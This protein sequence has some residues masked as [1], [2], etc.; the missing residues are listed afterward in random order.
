VSPARRRPAAG[1]LP[2]RAEILEFLR[3]A[4]G[5]AKPAEI[6][7]AFGVKGAERAELRR[8]LRA[9]AGDGE[10]DRGE[11]RRLRPAGS[12]PP[13]GV[14]EVVG[15]DE[16]GEALAR[17][18]ERGN[19]DVPVRI[20]PGRHGR[21]PAT[22]DRV[23]ARLREGDDGWEGSV[24]RVLPQRAD[25]VVGVLARVGSGLHLRPATRGGGTEHVVEADGGAEP[26]DLVLAEVAP[27]GRLGLPRARVVER[28]GKPDDPAAISLLAA[29][30]ADI[31]LV[32]PAD[33][34]A[35][36]DRAAPVG[37]EG[38]TD[39]RTLPL[40]TIDGEDARDF[41][42]A[43]H[44]AADDDP[45]NPGGW[46]VTVA[47][48]D[49]AWYVR[50]G[51][52]IDREAALRGNS[53]Y[54]PDRV[55]PMLPEALSADLCSLRPDE[56]RACLAVHMRIGADGRLRSHRLDRGL[57]RSAARLTYEQVQDAADGRPDATAAPLMDAVIRPLYGAF[58]ALEAERK[59]RGTL[60]LDLP[61]M[62][63]V[64]DEA[65]R[66]IRVAPRPRL[67]SH[68]LIEAFMIAA[69]VAAAETLERVGQ[70]CMYRV[71]DKPDP[72]KIEA[73]T[74][75]LQSLGERASGATLRRPADFGRLLARFEGHE[76]APM[77]NGFVLRCQAQAVYSPDNLGHF[78]LGLRRYA[79]FTSP[80]RRYADLLV[81][82]AMIRGLGLG[83]GGL[84]SDAGRERFVRTGEHI[85]GTERQAMA[86]ERRALDR[87]VSLYLAERTGAEFDGW[88][89]AVQRFGLFVRL[90]AVGVDGLVPISTLG[91]EYFRHDPARHVLVGETSGTA[92]GLG[93]RVRVELA[94]AD[95]VSGSLALR[96]LDSRPGPAVRAWQADSGRARTDKASTRRIWRKRAGR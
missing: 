30:E 95:P 7:R 76:L 77:L 56:D 70:P 51:D 93:D 35:Q 58:A 10:L 31:R 28:I 3:E 48:A 36:A 69:N 47:I 79:H 82:R 92:Y 29:Y 8:R 40:V 91:A 53:V 80:I 38:R 63:V 23:L 64:T 65:H 26:G 2:D 37:P 11:R 61:E 74:Q 55:V 66:P 59:A 75:F 49:V 14:L 62:Q 60:D 34:L 89:A 72:V 52:A 25:R 41:D 71:H 86:A 45:G 9:L 1:R 83:E 81:H 46:R 24:I 21:A 17:P 27:G 84:P 68:R 94:E 78:G 96:L 85:S 73:L 44:A 87:F 33:A 4:G 88:V 15:L 54:F 39:L 42:D 18:V 57:M 90:E 50:P 5:E 16:S 12:L 43:V 6:A 13:V 32:F 19:P 22:G 20:L 67:A